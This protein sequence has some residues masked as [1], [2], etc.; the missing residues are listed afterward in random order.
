MVPVT[1]TAWFKSRRRKPKKEDLYNGIPSLHLSEKR[2]RIRRSDLF[3]KR[4]CQ[5]PEIGPQ[6][7][8]YVL[9]V[10]NLSFEKGQAKH[11]DGSQVQAEV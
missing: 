8:L 11:S 1:E 6:H 4:D 7:R 3:L 2:V 10:T 9:G 5:P